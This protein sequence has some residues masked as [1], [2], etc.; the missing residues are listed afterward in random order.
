M[1]TRER[2]LRTEQEEG[3]TS[4]NQQQLPRHPKRRLIAIE[5]EEEDE[6]EDDGANIEFPAFEAQVELAESSQARQ[7]RPN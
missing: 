2:L 7:E 5:E 4:T 6:E 3:P 1:H